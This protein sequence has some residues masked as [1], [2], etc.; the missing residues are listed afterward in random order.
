MSFAICCSRS[1][2]S[3]VALLLL[4][5]MPGDDHRRS[6]VIIVRA[7]LRCIALLLLVSCYCCCMC[8]IVLVDIILLSCYIVGAYPRCSACFFVLWHFVVVR[9]SIWLPLFLLRCLLLLAIGDV[10]CIDI[11]A[12]SCSRGWLLV[13]CHLVTRCY[14]GCIVCR[15]LIDGGGG[16]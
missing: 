11:G 7:V 2:H 15:C 5:L 4:L 6:F 12:G 10:G 1:V 14:S 3:V 13:I 16:C 9:C 8:D